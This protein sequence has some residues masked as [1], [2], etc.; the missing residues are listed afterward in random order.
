MGE[1]HTPGLAH[2]AWHAWPGTPSSPPWPE[3]PVCLVGSYS[4]SRSEAEQAEFPVG[5]KGGFKR[6]SYTKALI[7]AGESG[8]LSARLAGSAGRR[9]QPLGLSLPSAAC[10]GGRT[11]SSFSH[12][13]VE[14]RLEPG[15]CSALLQD[16][17]SQRAVCPWLFH[18]RSPTFTRHTVRPGLQ[19]WTNH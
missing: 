17:Q 3:A 8:D 16:A 7:A 1:H 15:V 2:L 11:T 5:W 13:G 19:G 18:S 6:V 14:S 12:L 9:R 4:A 10:A